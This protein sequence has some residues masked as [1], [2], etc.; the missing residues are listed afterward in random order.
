MSQMPDDYDDEDNEVVNCYTTKEF[1]E[2][3]EKTPGDT[4]IYLRGEGRFRVPDVDRIPQHVTATEGVT[5]QGGHPDLHLN[6]HCDAV[7]FIEQAKYVWTCSRR[8]CDTRNTD[9]VCAV[10]DAPLFSQNCGVVQ[11]GDT[12]QV[13]AFDCETVVALDRARVALFGKCYCLAFERS[14]VDAGDNA[15]CM[16]EAHDFSRVIAESSSRIAYRSPGA[17]I[18]TPY[19][20]GDTIPFIGDGV[21]DWARTYGTHIDQKKNLLYVYKCVGSNLETGE[22]E[23]GRLIRH[24]VRWEV[25]RRSECVDWEASP[26]SR[27]GL[28]FAS[29]PVRAARLTI[30]SGERHMLRCA[31]PVDK[32]VIMNDGNSVKAPWADVIEE[33][34]FDW[35]QVP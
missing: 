27:H 4:L 26:R 16:I 18:I 31:I 33:I 9:S 35:R 3:V 11:A 17:T 21:E 30:Q 15:Y 28:H 32:T 22:L 2:A 29:H 20:G 6:A 24:P 5:L 25:G 14:D 12:S 13:S 10:D 34:E 7:T 1:R 23:T 8:V 19:G